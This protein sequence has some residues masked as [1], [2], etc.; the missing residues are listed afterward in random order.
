MEIS[1]SETVGSYELRVGERVTIVQQLGNKHGGSPP[2]A[3]DYYFSC[4][5]DSWPRIRDAIE[6]MLSARDCL[7]AEL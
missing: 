4:P 3:S 2:T 5:V 7:E 1:V 6:R